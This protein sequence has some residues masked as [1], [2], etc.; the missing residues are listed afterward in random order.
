MSKGLHERQAPA[1]FPE[2]LTQEACVQAFGSDKAYL[3]FARQNVFFNISAVCNG[4]F[5]G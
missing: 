2:L 4:Q 1:R 3:K 5:Y